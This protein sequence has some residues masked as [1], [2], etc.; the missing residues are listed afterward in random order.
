M[1][2]GNRWQKIDSWEWPSSYGTDLPFQRCQSDVEI[3]VDTEQRTVELAVD[4]GVEEVT[5]L[6]M[7]DKGVERLIEALSAAREV[8][9]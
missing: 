1:S 3:T 6:T 9:R 7:D 2:D 4:Q 5:N 8:A